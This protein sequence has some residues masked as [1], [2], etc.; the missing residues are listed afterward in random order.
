MTC[1]EKYQSLALSDDYISDPLLLALA[2]KKSQQY[3]RSTSW[4]ADHFELDLSALDLAD[5]C[6]EWAK[7]IK[8]DSLTFAAMHLVPAPKSNPWAFKTPGELRAD[9][10]QPTPIPNSGE[11][12]L[13]W[14]PAPVKDAKVD[15]KKIPLRPLAHT[16][17]REQ[18]MM[19]LVMMCLANAVEAEQGDPTLDF[20]HVHSSKVY[21]Y[22]NRLHCQY[23]NGKVEHSYGGTTAYRKYFT[24]YQQFL[25]RPDHFAE[26][27]SDEIND[28][29]QIYVVEIDL[30]K[31]FD[32]IDRSLLVEKIKHLSADIKPEA[33]ANVDKLLR[34]FAAWEWSDS[35]KAQY[36]ALY[37]DSAPKGLPQGLVASGFFSNIYLLDF[38]QAVGAEIGKPALAESAPFSVELIDYCR[39]VDDLRLVILAPKIKL[40]SEVTKQSI[41]KAAEEF[42]EGH[43]KKAELKELRI[44]E[45]KTRLNTYR[46][47]SHGISSELRKMQSRLSGPISF[48]DAMDNLGVLNSLLSVSSPGTPQDDGS[49]C[50]LNRLAQ[51]E[52]N[53]LDLR[54]ET[55]KRFAANKIARLLKDARHFSAHE[56]D[57]GGPIPGDWDHQQEQYARRFISCWSYDPSLVLLL[58]KGLE[59]FPCTRL[60]EPVLEQLTPRLATD[61]PS[62]IRAVARYCLAEI[63]RHAATIIHQQD[64]HMIPVHA[65]VDAFFERIQH[66]AAE[67]AGSCNNEPGSEFDLLAEQARFLLLVRLDSSLEAPGSESKHDVIF[68]LASGFRNIT[69]PNGMDEAD[70]AAC[71]ILA[72]QIVE[73]NK[74]LIKAVGSL[75]A[76]RDED[77]IGIL[78]RLA[79]QQFPFLQTLILHARG[80]KYDW[81]NQEAIREFAKLY[82][83]DK[84]PWSKPLEKIKGEQSLLRLI[85]RHDNPF[86]NEVMALKLMKALLDDKTWQQEVKASSLIDLAE[87]KVTFDDYANPPKFEAFGA[88]SKLSVIVK[89]MKKKPVPNVKLTGLTIPFLPHPDLSPHL[90][91]EDKTAEGKESL[92][93][94][95]VAMCMRSVLMG[96]ADWT[97]HSKA[98]SPMTGYRGIKSNQYKR[99]LGLFTTPFAVGGEAAQVSDW[100][101]ALLAKILAWPG[102]SMSAR[103]YPWPEKLS[104]VEVKNIVSTRLEEM[105]QLYCRQSQMP[106]LAEK[107][108]L[109]WDAS[110]KNLTVAMVQSKMPT[111]KDFTEHGFLLDDPAYRAKHRKHIATVATLVCKHIK[112]QRKDCTSKEKKNQ[113]VDLIVWPELAVHQDDIDILTAL[114]RKTHAIIFAGLTFIEQPDIKG[115]NNCAIWIV[116]RKRNTKQKELIRYQ[117]K[118]HMTTEEK[119]KVEPWRPYQLMLELMHPAFPDEGGFKVTGSICYDATDIALSA[120]LRDKSNAYVV[121]AL[122]R[123]INTFDTMIDALH[124]HM[125]QPVVLVNSGEFGGSCAKA[126]YKD[127]FDRLIAHSHGNDQV[128][129]NTFE[130]NMF[131]FRKDSF[132]N[133]LRSGKA[134]KT[135]PAGWRR[136]VTG[137]SI[138]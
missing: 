71:I 22:G 3:I 34:A 84:R 95:R 97:A 43:L 83:V 45:N 68:K 47:R 50:R 32:R 138:L 132:G 38:D 118:Q 117:G 131:D 5:K 103:N 120:D 110:K 133:S 86:A 27:A 54:E 31:F 126:P 106:G 123:D 113:Q 2:W 39:Y 73:D 19:T 17:I 115:P 109:D 90:T 20:E 87:T 77:V 30:S 16:R 96:V 82:G 51:M 63:F 37:D 60:L 93:L 40:G 67:I 24:D 52:S 35:A 11:E 125:Y 105:E 33:Q 25:S 134:L 6:Q 13:I 92:T 129:I 12:R 136:D 18:T 100:F 112:A 119:G 62:Y 94:Q 128:S 75:L 111:N 80:V 8:E 91:G 57:N 41:Q 65:D 88:E 69:I 1:L 122:N 99:M 58:K 23:D 66:E 28:D 135:A 107:V 130:M 72:E 59:L 42:I 56:V 10:K 44:N 7:N 36:Q 98:T 79:E 9:P 116:P 48:D 101:T 70:I 15:D 14:V 85:Q 29:R 137:T 49:G 53:H 108:H 4:Y 26:L 55:V 46:K 64:R 89:F 124:Y 102:I 74:P 127:S 104:L 81:V 78:K 76:K 121:S 114:S 61:T 21:S